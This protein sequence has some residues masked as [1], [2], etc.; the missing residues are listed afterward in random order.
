VRITEIE[1]LPVKPR[2]LIVRLCTDEGV[3]GYGE[4]TL[5]GHIPAVM[6]EIRHWEPELMGQDPRR[7]EHI[8]QGLYRH[9]FYRGGPIQCSAIS[10]LEQAMWDITGKWLGVPL[11]MLLGGRVRDRIR[12]YRHVG[13]ATAAELAAD[14]RQAVAA[15]FDAI[16]IS[17][18]EAGIRHIDSLRVVEGAVER[19][20]AAREAVGKGVDIGVDM[21]GRLSPAMAIGIA[22]ALEP[23]HPFFIEEPVLPEQVDALATVARATSI[24]VATGERLLTKWGFREVL[25]KQAAALL[26]PDP[27]H[28]GGIMECRFIA[29]MAETYFVGMAP[30]CPLG[31]VALAACLQLDA[32]TPNFLIQEH[33]TLGDGYLR[34]PYRAQGGY[35]P[36][37]DKPGLGIELDEAALAEKADDGSWHNPALYADD[38]AVTDW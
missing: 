14:A 31:P 23:Y 33:V 25:E 19:M 4:A 30:H 38:G 5:E 24:P 16:K 22:K 26:Q 7:I 11:W 32:C 10:G 17:V 27:C 28:A 6:A 18:T 2:W 8:W 9:A 12:L 1:L 29:A 20:A 15:G 34:H 36:V 3:T 37:S 21:H 13:G 35:L